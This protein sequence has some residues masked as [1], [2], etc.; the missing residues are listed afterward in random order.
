MKVERNASGLNEFDTK[1]CSLLNMLISGLYENKVKINYIK[2]FV[3]D[4]NGE[5]LATLTIRQYKLIKHITVTI[6]TKTQKNYLDDDTVV[7]FTIDH[8]EDYF[9]LNH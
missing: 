7:K 5:V 6:T 3:N 2:D 4:Y 1:A 8:L 9:Y